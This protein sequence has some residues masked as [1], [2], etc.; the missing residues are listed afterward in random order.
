MK[1]KKIIRLAKVSSKKN[2]K[3]SRKTGKALRKVAS[4]GQ[5]Q[6]RKLGNRGYAISDI[7]R[8]KSNL[9]QMVTRLSVG[10]KVQ[11]YA[12]I[13]MQLSK[14]AG[15]SDD[16]VWSWR[17][18]A[19]VHSGSIVPGKK[20]IKAYMLFQKNISPRQKQWFYF[21]NR[22]Y[23]AAIYNKTILSE[24]IRTNM[25]AMG[26]RSVTFS[27]YAEIKRKSLCRS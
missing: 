26:F 16:H 14:L 15:M 7:Q 22:I 2:P 3:A 1:K 21:S 5:K 12:H 6:V 23:V 8:I 11:A 20:F 17:Y 13:A 27:K 9:S 10:G 24:I 19:S 18:I 4:T 25:Q